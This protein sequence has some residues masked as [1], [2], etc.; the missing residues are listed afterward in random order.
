MTGDVGLRA[1]QTLNSLLVGFQWNVFLQ[2]TT[3]CNAKLAENAALRTEIYLMLVARG[4][5]HN[6]FKALKRQIAKDK[7]KMFDIVKQ[8]LRTY[9]IR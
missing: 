3:R 9:E 2:A 6:R 5:F 7:L 8:G 1:T 4:S